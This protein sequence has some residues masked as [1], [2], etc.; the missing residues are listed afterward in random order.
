MSERPK[1]KGTQAEEPTKKQRSSPNS[2]SHT[3]ANVDHCEEGSPAE[4]IRLDKSSQDPITFKH[5]QRLLDN[6][7]G[8]PYAAIA[9]T[10]SGQGLQWLGLRT[11]RLTTGKHTGRTI[12][13][14][15]NPPLERRLGH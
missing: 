6:V 9:S 11:T 4:S 10:I 1:C 2:T 12:V 7:K 8:H 5:S 13:E 3:M 14:I 15:G